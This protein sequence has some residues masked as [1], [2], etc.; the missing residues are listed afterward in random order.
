MRDTQNFLSVRGCR[1]SPISPKIH[2]PDKQRD[3]VRDI[4]HYEFRYINHESVKVVSY[5]MHM[6]ILTRDWKVIGRAKVFG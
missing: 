6:D 4:L 1:R 5:V 2:V 3:A